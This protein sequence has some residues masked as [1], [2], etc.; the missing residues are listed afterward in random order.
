MYHHYPPNSN[1]ERQ[2]NIP[3]MIGGLFGFPTSNPPFYGPPPMYQNPY[4]PGGPQPNQPTAPQTDG[5]PTTPPPNFT[6]TQPNFQT[7]AIDPGAIRGCL[8]RFTYVW[9]NRESFW[10]YPVFIGRQSV[11]GYRWRRNRWVYFGIDLDRIQSF[12]C[13]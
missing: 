1:E 10:F 11:A 4:Y 7:F 12:Q 5:P 8:F 9:L 13:F 3:G 6:P 2:I